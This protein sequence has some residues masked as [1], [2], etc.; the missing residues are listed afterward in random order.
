MD[1]WDDP[2]YWR[3]LMHAPEIAGGTPSREYL[4]QSVAQ[5]MNPHVVRL[6]T[7]HGGVALFPQRN[8][9][10]HVMVFHRKDGWGAPVIAA[11]IAGLDWAFENTAAQII[12]T[13]FVSTTKTAEWASAR[14]GMR[15][16][17]DETPG[18]LGQSGEPMTM[19]VFAITRPEWSRRK[20]RSA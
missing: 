2:V 17:R 16:V 8:G 15:H 5:I 11:L 4:D 10:W 18:T 13:D 20:Q 1:L 14:A 7:E 19:R 3:D 6:K 9:L 12:E